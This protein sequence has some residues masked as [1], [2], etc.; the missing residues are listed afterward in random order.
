MICGPLN[1]I[2]PSFLPSITFN[3]LSASTILTNTSDTGIPTDPIFDSPF[4]GFTHAA[5]SDSVRP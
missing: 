4:T 2:S 3:G 5:M 1:S